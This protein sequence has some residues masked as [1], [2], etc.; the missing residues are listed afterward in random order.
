[1]PYTDL[2]LCQRYLELREFI[3]RRAKEQIA[4]LE[5]YKDGMKAIEGMMQLALNER[6]ANNSR[7]EGVGTFFKVRTTAARVTDP[8]AF[9][10]HVLETRNT[11]LLT[12]A[13]AKDAV[14]AFMDANGG[15]Q[16]PGVEITYIDKVNVRKA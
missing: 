5:P 16:P 10:A 2:Q 8:A 7:V 9:F 6:G 4:E 11:N 12:S 13:V 14:Q 1:M 3:E 15:H